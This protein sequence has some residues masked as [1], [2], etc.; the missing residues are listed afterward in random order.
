MSVED[1]ILAR[2]KAARVWDKESRLEDFQITAGDN[3]YVLVNLKTGRAQL[4]YDEDSRLNDWKQLF[5]NLVILSP[6]QGAD[7]GG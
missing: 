7:K 4:I 3:G 5:P 2:I 1:E 6:E